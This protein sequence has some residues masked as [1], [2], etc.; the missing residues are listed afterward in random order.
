LASALKTGAILS[1]IG[2]TMIIL[3]IFISPLASRQLCKIQSGV[4]LPDITSQDCVRGYTLGLRNTFSVPGTLL[5]L[6][7]L[8]IVI[9]AEVNRTGHK[10][11]NRTI[12]NDWGDKS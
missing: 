9:M 7:G 6:I 12:G 5:I 8:F 1:I 2:F 4:V 11:P 10:I 3:I